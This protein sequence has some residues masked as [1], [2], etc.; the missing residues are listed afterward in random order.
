MNCRIRVESL[1]QFQQV[2]RVGRG[3]Q[4]KKLAIHPGFA[5]GDLLVSNI[6]LAR[7]IISH[8][9][10]RKARR[11]SIAFAESENSLRNFASNLQSDPLPIQYF[12]AHRGPS[13]VFG[14]NLRVALPTSTPKK[15]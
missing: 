8:Q 9:N 4:A 7:W 12:R 14:T 11:N 15:F 10:G 1:E 3:G 2:F 13:L 6:D 5:T